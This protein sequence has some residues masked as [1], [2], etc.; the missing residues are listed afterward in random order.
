MHIGPGTGPRDLRAITCDRRTAMRW[1]VAPILG[2]AAAALA[3]NPARPVTIAVRG[4]PAALAPFRDGLAFGAAE[5]G[6]TAELLGFA[7]RVD[8]AG[9][10]GEERGRDALRPVAVLTADA[11]PLP[12]ESLEAAVVVRLAPA[13]CAER[14]LDAAVSVAARFARRLETLADWC[15]AAHLDRWIL[16]T[17]DPSCGEPRLREVTEVVAA[18]GIAVAATDAGGTRVE[19]LLAR[20]RTGRRAVVCLLDPA[21]TWPEFRRRMVGVSPRPLVIG[22]T[23]PVDEQDGVWP[24]EAW[25]A[26]WHASLSRFGARELNAR[27]AARFDRPMDSRS[28]LGWMAVR[29]S[30][31][32]ALRG[33]GDLRAGLALLRL[34]GHKGTA[35]RFDA[36][37]FLRQPL[38]VVGR[39]VD[40]G[41]LAVLHE[42]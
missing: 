31:E 15:V 14:S 38:L 17:R 35:L 36:D 1:L 29:A 8:E 34:D 33:S 6:R 3:A 16:V 4:A 2:P 28:W 9:A 11:G 5:A 21:D 27:F 42:G 18:R 19:A 26:E 25:G 22:P 13:G 12:E 20:T 7:L 24:G 32:A 10:G 41:P 37:G 30:V 23:G 39:D 40:G